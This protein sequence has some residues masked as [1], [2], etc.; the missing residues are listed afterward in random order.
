MRMKT[1]PFPS[2]VKVSDEKCSALWAFAAIFVIV[3]LLTSGLLQTVIAA[4]IPGRKITGRIKS[5]MLEKQVAGA[6]VPHIRFTRYYNGFTSAG[7]GF[8]ENCGPN[9]VYS[10]VVA[11]GTYEV[12]AALPEVGISRRR[13]IN[14]NE[15]LS[16]ISEMK[17]EIPAVIK[18]RLSNIPEGDGVRKSVLIYQPSGFL[19]HE[20]EIK[21]NND[22]EIPALP[23]RY[24][25]RHLI[26]GPLTSRAWGCLYPALDT[27]VSLREGEVHEVSFEPKD[28]EYTLG[29][30]I[31][32]LSDLNV[33]MLYE[34]G[35]SANP[36]T[37]RYYSRVFVGGRQDAEYLFPNLKPGRY[38]LAVFDYI[39][40]EDK[41]QNPT[42]IV[43]Y[44][45][46]GI[47][48]G[49]KDT[50]LDIDLQIPSKED[51][52]VIEGAVADEGDFGVRGAVIEIYDKRGRLIATTAS[53]FGGRYILNGLPPGVD[54]SVKVK[55]SHDRLFDG[56]V[57]VIF[58][59]EESNPRL[60]D[61]KETFKP[62]SGRTEKVIKIPLK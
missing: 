53:D 42:L 38:E 58:S 22:Y 60:F 12:Y 4:E 30:G 11:T 62:K 37:D 34:K 50:I 24:E 17:V 57:S 3:L 26:E 16:A 55:K 41:E 7:G 46:D 36:A 20:K 40:P 33:I 1:Y 49:R 32:G 51:S 43:R 28:T 6:A 48:V 59:D 13:I 14:V 10:A 54:Y 45:N 29:G 25:V 39:E 56:G 18:G 15:R 9:G 47:T 8:S 27:V 44:R 35:K 19:A 5:P 2:L 52:S 23:G 21:E 61:I 31:R